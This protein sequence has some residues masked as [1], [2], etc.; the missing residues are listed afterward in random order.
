[1]QPMAKPNISYVKLKQ[2][3]NAVGVTDKQR[4]NRELVAQLLESAY[5]YI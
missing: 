3:A 5:G 1:M 2:V 4:F